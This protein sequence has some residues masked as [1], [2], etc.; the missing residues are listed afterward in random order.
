MKPFI[1]IDL[2]E[3]RK[4][5]RFNGEEFVVATASEDNLKEF[6]SI[7]DSAKKLYKKTK[8]PLALR[9]LQK[10]CIIA[11]A[12]F[13]VLIIKETVGDIEGSRFD[14]V[15]AFNNTPWIFWS[16]LGCFVAWIVLNIASRINTMVAMKRYAGYH[17]SSKLS[18]V[19][20]D[21]YEE[22]DIPIDAINIDLL[23]FKYKNKKGKLKIKKGSKRIATFVNYQFKAYLS[24]KKLYLA[25]LENKY[26]FPL[27]K[28]SAI[29]TVKANTFVPS[30]H[31][32]LSID[33]GIYKNYSLKKDDYGFIH[34]K[35]YHILELEHKGE[36]FGIY[37]PSYELFAFEAFTGL[38][39]EPI[40]KKKSC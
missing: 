32:D 28:M 37:F 4:N 18:S 6:K 16:A 10:L 38:T 17:A 3:N 21:I 26:A 2:T 39:A 36:K 30:W 27:D 19:A 35:N 40:N 11:S 8:F 24:D 25:D 22:F 13:A 7:S 9:I 5:E 15:A 20:D 33:K 29:H 31:K 12:V 1:G 34:F 14:V 23:S